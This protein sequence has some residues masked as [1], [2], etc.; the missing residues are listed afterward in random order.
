M[1]K[2]PPYQKSVIIGLMLSDGWLIFA[3]TTNKNARLGF[4]Q[5][6]NQSIFGLYFLC[7]LIIV[8]LTLY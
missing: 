1:I 4:F 2:L 8:L 6:V 7:Y 5:S 3:S